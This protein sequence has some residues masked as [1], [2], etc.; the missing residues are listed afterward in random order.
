MS[1]HSNVLMGAYVPELVFN[2]N[3]K[4]EPGKVRENYSSDLERIMITTDRISAFDV[5]MNEGVPDKGHALN[6]ISEYWFEKTK[7]IVPNHI[8]KVLDPSVWLVH[9]CKPY[10]VEVIVRGHLAGSAAADYAK[11]MRVK[12][13]VQLP[14]G[15]KR[16]QKFDQPILTPTTKAAR[17][18]HDEDISRE[19]VIE[20]GLVDAGSYK[21]IEEIA[22]KLFDR[23]TELAKQN[24]LILVDTKYEFGVG[25][26]GI[27]LTDEIHTPD[28]SRFWH[29]NDYE[30]AMTEGRDPKQL[31][32]EFLRKWLDGQ[33]FTGQTPNP[34]SLP[35]E[36]VGE[37]S[38]R[39]VDLYKRVTGREFVRS[40]V[41]IRQRVLTAL[42]EAG[43]I[44]GKFVPIIAGSEK[45][46]PHYQKITERLE[47][48]SCPYKVFNYSAHKQA[49]E[50][51]PLMDMLETSIEPIAIIDVAGLSNALGGFLAGNM[52]IKHPVINCPPFA[53][54]QAYQIDIHSSM[55][56][57]SGVPAAT[58]VN[59]ENAADFAVIALEEAERLL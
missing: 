19:Q 11:G 6:G 16:N 30:P 20:L 4:Y 54:L 12:S 24:G 43:Y 33:G 31:S 15:L 56:M 9:E 34:P 49:R 51:L 26:D 27:T 25:P 5:V 8:K 23:G 58:I 57:P 1:A 37:V 28:S 22:L 18:K 13:G 3:M 2:R 46:A 32:K 29:S 10:L 7:D 52:R 44:K 36:V 48:H 53:D 38:V 39:Y 45:D 40:A 14:E 59:P 50:L 35:A 55:R 21:T 41:P 47:K 17:G 42:R